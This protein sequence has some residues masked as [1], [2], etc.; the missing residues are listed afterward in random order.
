[1]KI[2]FFI[3]SLNAGGAERVTT[4]MANYWANKAYDITILTIAPVTERQY[5]LSERVNHLSLE[6]DKCSNNIF[7][8]LLNNV[9]RIKSLTSEIKKQQADIVI[10]MMSEANVLAAI[11]CR[12]LPTKSIGSERIHPTEL[13]IGFLWKTLRR[14]SYRYLSLLVTQTK[15]TEEWV[16]KH[17]SVKRTTTIPNP[18]VLP[19]PSGSPVV[20]PDI[21]DDEFLILGVGRLTTQKQFTHLITAFASLS[22]HHPNW[23]MA[24][25]GEGEDHAKLSA[26][27]EERNLSNRVKLIGRVGNVAYWYE[28]ADIFAL[29]SLTEGFPNVL[30]EAMAHSTAVISYNCPTG[31]N[32]IITHGTNGLLVEA[33]NIKHLTSALNQ[34]ILEPKLRS[35]LARNAA[36]TIKT[37][38][39]ELIMKQWE[40][41]IDTIVDS[42]P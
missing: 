4:H 40:T 29:T 13:N 26:F 20:T 18:L 14:F 33:N 28:R 36:M 2:V 25:V 31:P 30:I 8:A 39:I 41:A 38:D 23:T 7:D 21:P 3:H 34:L 5:P 37:Y 27:I 12:K 10:S 11:A 24:I 9:K 17:T 1:V 15:Q 32:E 35:E 6:T 19:I 22:A 16:K 42:Q